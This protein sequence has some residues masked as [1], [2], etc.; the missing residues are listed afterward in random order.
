MKRICPYCGKEIDDTQK[1]CVHCGHRVDATIDDYEN[2]SFWDEPEVHINDAGVTKEVEPKHRKR[3]LI[4][5]IIVLVAISAAFGGAL[6]ATQVANKTEETSGSAKSSGE[7]VEVEPDD[8]HKSDDENSE[9]LLNASSD[10]IDAITASST[11]TD[12]KS[13][14]SPSLV[15]DGLLSTAWSEAESGITGAKLTITYKNTCLMKGFKINAGYQKSSDLYDKNARPKTIT[16][17]VSDDNG[18]TYH[19]R[20]DL[21]DTMGVQTVS[22]INSDVKAKSFTIMI[23]DAYPGTEYADCCISEIVPY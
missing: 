12:S 18:E 4:V 16:V 19:D 17:S 5:L 10:T 2:S 3:V 9:T 22:F 14:H 21:S 6:F 8:T 23:D 13:T 7:S 11:L 1:F 20:Y 15:S